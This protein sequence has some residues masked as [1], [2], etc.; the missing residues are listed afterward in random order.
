MSND[1]WLDTCLRQ[2]HK[3]TGDW[4]GVLHL[5]E[6]QQMLRTHN[7]R[8]LSVSTCMRGATTYALKANINK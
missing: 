1:P 7:G 5:Q 8:G 3:G 2:E 4:S 6:G